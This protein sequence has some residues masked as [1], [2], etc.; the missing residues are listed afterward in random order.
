MAKSRLLRLAKMW[1]PDSDDP[2][3]EDKRRLIRYLLEHNVSSQAPITIPRIQEQV[4]FTKNYSRNV[5][6]H[7]LLGPLRRDARVFIGTSPKGLFLVTRPED[8]DATLGFY[9]WRVRAEL[10]HAR[11]LRTLAKRTKLLEGYV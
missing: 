9:T 2:F 6:Q 1:T 4:Q 7:K 11:N 8:V 10:R 3:G 5:I